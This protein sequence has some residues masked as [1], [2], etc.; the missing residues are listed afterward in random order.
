VPQEGEGCTF[1][2]LHIRISRMKG[3]KIEEVIVTRK[4]H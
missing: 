3:P 1:K 4:E 2:N